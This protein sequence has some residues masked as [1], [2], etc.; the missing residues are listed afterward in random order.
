MI[1]GSGELFRVNPSNNGGLDKIIVYP[2]NF[3][4]Q[5]PTAP[6]G[7]I[8]KAKQPNLGPDGGI[9]LYESIPGPV[10]NLTGDTAFVNY[11]LNW[12]IPGSE[13]DENNNFIKR[14]PN[15]VDYYEV[16][17]STGRYISY[18]LDGGSTSLLLEEANNLNG[19]RRIL[20]DLESYGSVP[21]EEIDIAESIVDARNI[22]DVDARSL[23]LEA[24]HKGEV[25]DRR[26]FWVRPVD[27]AGNKGTFRW[28]FF[29]WEI[30]LKVWS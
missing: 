29:R 6:I 26:F 24:T 20:G 17:E 9:I 18:S 22:F 7:E 19:Y 23:S 21:V 13:R 2:K 16:W 10:Q 28:V 15:D 5:N 25:N 12:D 1:L 3:H 11:F 30:M 27:F 8:P 14:I 4:S